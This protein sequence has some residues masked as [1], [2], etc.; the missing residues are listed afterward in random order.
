MRIDRLATTLLAFC[1]LLTGPLSLRAD[2]QDAALKKRA[3]DVIHSLKWQTGT[4]TLQGGLAKINLTDNFR[5]LD[6][7]DANKVLHDLWGNP[8]NSDILGMIVP[9][10]DGPMGDDRWAVT[11][12]YE[13]S[14][15][16]KDDDAGKIDY[17]DLLKKMKEDFAKGSEE[18]VKQGYSTVELL[19]WAAPPRYDKEAHKLY[20][21]KNLKFGDTDEQTLNYDIRILGRH[22]VLVLRAIA[23]TSDLPA[24]EKRAPEILS[25]VDFQPGN[26][27]SEFDPK[28]DKVAEYGLA[29][30]IA[31]GVVA[32]AAKLGLLGAF[33]K[34]IV[35][36][37]LALKKA[38]IVVVVAVIAGAK[39]LWS[40]ITGGKAKT[41][42]NLL[43]PPGSQ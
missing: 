12:N 31:G 40:A 7:A 26:T 29:G 19:G 17:D 22:G 24:I 33:F 9:N 6:A 10:G 34:W 13:D 16:V 2:D 15:Y 8:S 20:W 23:A 3:D 37:V 4:I 28:I 36:A 5:F 39:K 43:P 25:M 38:L 27:Y 1:Y 18:R 14:G 30:L 35:V 11:V 42:D 41:P 21:A 32:G